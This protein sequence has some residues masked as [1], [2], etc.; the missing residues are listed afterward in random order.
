MDLFPSLDLM[1]IFTGLSAPLKDS[2]AYL[3][4]GSGSFF[5]QL[6]IASLLGGLFVLKAYWTRIKAFFSRLFSKSPPDT[7]DQ[8]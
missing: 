2:P 3:D 7:E 5:L 6:L 4:P 1:A 8:K